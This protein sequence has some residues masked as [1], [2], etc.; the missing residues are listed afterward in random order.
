MRRALAFLTA[1][2]L[3]SVVF[4]AHA[5]EEWIPTGVWPFLNQRFMTA[6]VVTGFI[7]KKKTQMP[8]N[9]HVGSQQLWY[10]QDDTMMVAD[11]G[12]VSRVTFPNGDVYVPIGSSTFGKIVID[13][14]V[15]KVVRV[16]TVDKEEFEARGRD[17]SNMA[18]FTLSG[19]FGDIGMDLIG[20]YDAHPEEKPLPVLDTFYFIYNLEI[21]EC[22]DKEILKRI[23]KERHREYRAFTRSAEIIMRHESSVRKIWDQFFRKRE[24]DAKKK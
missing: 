1:A 6:E 7:Y 22:T 16:R 14:S 15:G 19:S 8:C 5:Q 23:P 4:C 13:D 18:S 11:A 12:I 20:Q 21:F 17:A 24:A 10:V 3:W 2:L 9:I